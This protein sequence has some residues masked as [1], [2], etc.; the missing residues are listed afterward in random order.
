M[1]KTAMLTVL[2][3]CIGFVS[4]VGVA[5]AAP[6]FKPYPRPGYQQQ[7]NG[8]RRPYPGPAGHHGP[9][10]YRPPQHGGEYR[11]PHHHRYCPMPPGLRHGYRIVKEEHWRDHHGRRHM[12]RIWQNRYGHRYYERVY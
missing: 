11:P 9:A 12:D 1:K 4:T 2:S 6:P 7:Y 5:D 3:L 10:V 8:P